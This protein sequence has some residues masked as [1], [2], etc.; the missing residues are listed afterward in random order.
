M[1]EA[2]DVLIIARALI[3]HLGADA[4]GACEERALAHWRD[5]ESEG[6][7]LWQRVADAARAILTGHAR[8][9]PRPPSPHADRDK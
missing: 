9:L 4:I 3:R 7:E 1:D 8:T 6:A 2:S 5:E